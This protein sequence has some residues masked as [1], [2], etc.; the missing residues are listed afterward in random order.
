MA[1]KKQAWCEVCQQSIIGTAVLDTETAQTKHWD[2]H[3][4]NCNHKFKY[5]QVQKPYQ[6]KKKRRVRP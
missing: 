6:G 4:P 3:C 5:T 1:R 2:V